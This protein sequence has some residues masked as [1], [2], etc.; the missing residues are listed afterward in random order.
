MDNSVSF[1][2]EY[3]SDLKTSSNNDNLK[4]IQIIFLYVDKDNNLISSRKSAILVRK[5]VI[6]KKK[7]IYLLKKN[8]INGDK[9]FYPSILL[10]YNICLNLDEIQHFVKDPYAYNFLSQEHYIQDIHWKNTIGILHKANSLYI[11]LHERSPSN[12]YTKKIYISKKKRRKTKRK[13][14]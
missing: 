8:S 12:K 11:I 2:E 7:L 5:N 13:Y 3:K 9:K 1:V 10:K 14:I 4:S 6:Y